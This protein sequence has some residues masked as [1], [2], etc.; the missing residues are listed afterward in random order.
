MNRSHYT[1]SAER[2]EK[3]KAA[4]AARRDQVRRFLW[5]YLLQHPCVD[6]GE[7]DPVVLDFDHVR[8]VKRKEVSKLVTASTKTLLEE[9]A[10]CDVRC[11]NCHRRRT[12][13]QLGHRVFCPR[14][15]DGDVPG[16]YPGEGD[17]S[18]PG[19]SIVLPS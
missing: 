3:V 9:I 16:S 14:S 11:A 10:K 1:S 15:V 5:D 2:R 17:S 13:I 7:A 8:G 19:G 12:A 6:C 4:A 18:A